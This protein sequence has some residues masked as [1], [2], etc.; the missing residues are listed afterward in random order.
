MEI[1]Q[2]IDMFRPAIIQIAT[3]QS[4]G[5]GFYLKNEKLIVTN[6]HVIR[7]NAEAVI[8][9]N[10]LTKQIAPVYFTDPRYDL[11]FI[12]APEGVELPE[13]RLGKN[14]PVKDGD[15]VIAIGH[16]Y[17]LNYTAT[18]G[19]VSKSSRVKNG[20]SYIQIDAA[21]NPGNSGGPLVN[22][23]GEVVGV[24][25]FIIAGGDNLGFALPVQYL[26]EDLND[27]KPYFGTYATR[28]ISCSAIVSE[29]NIDD[30][31]CPN[32]GS[33]IKMPSRK[34]EEYKPTG[35][36]AVIESIIEALGKDVRLSRIGPYS[37]ELEEGSARI[38]INYN[39]DGFIVLD[40][41]LCVLPKTNISAIYEFLLRENYNLE[42]MMFS[43]NQQ[44]IVLSTF[45]FD[46]Y[47]TFDSG[48][49][50]F[51]RFIETADKYDTILIENFGALKRV[52][53]EN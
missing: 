42:S 20:I 41:F 26:D 2:I 50:A 46:Q 7:G 10:N 37:W 45:L 38:S 48:L 33:E 12:R 52:T 18:E 11:A 35:T 32:C 44:N 36:S 40:S 13:I 39:S 1:Q 8:G 29:N 17:G 27:Y 34:E 51:R 5:T 31:Y 22:L 21:I 15:T 49:E 4:T 43:V 28:C 25:T 14:S 19:I 6:N 3:P 47:L 30:K 23:D 16:P 24:N 53:D 9:G